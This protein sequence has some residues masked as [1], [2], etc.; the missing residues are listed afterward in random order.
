MHLRISRE[1][2]RKIIHMYSLTQ[3]GN[4]RLS[5]SDVLVMVWM[6]GKS[7]VERTGTVLVLAHSRGALHLPVKNLDDNLL[8]YLCRNL[9]CFTDPQMFCCHIH[10]P[11]YLKLVLWSQTECE[12]QGM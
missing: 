10:A 8:L 3:A 6:K 4:R 7:W 2:K 11:T 12:L 1:S 5:T 9:L